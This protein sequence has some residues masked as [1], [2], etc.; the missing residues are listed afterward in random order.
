M[1]LCSFSTKPGC[2]CRSLTHNSN[3]PVYSWPADTSQGQC[4][5]DRQ[6]RPGYLVI[7]LGHGG[8]ISCNYNFF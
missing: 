1:P 7:S 2:Q 6:E 3:L 8:Y 5:R 4:N